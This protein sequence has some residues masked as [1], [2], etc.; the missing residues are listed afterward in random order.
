[1]K[2]LA[3]TENHLYSKVYAKGRRYVTPTVS[4]YILPD[5]SAKRIRNAHPQKLLRNRVGLT[6]TKKI[7]GAVT[8]NRCKRVMR[9][10]LRSI[11][12]KHK[13]KK[14]FLCVLVA[15]KDTT[16][17]KSTQVE[18]DMTAALRALDM[19]LD[20]PSK[21]VAAKDRRQTRTNGK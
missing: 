21:N 15:R 19:L 16:A 13:L 8:R 20:L 7:G 17:A 5:Y 2:E 11:E 3:I 1:M 10:A 4:V 6:V 12:S 9:A 18:A 14:G